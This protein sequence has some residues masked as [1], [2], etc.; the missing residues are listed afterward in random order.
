MKQ[1][2]YEF[3]Q[4]SASEY[5]IV[6]VKKYISHMFERTSH[7]Q[8]QAR[9]RWCCTLHLWKSEKIQCNHLP[10]TSFSWSDE[11]CHPIFTLV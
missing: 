11:D 3:R 10:A 7:V 9:A 6:N 8:H 4:K 5:K 2:L 1:S